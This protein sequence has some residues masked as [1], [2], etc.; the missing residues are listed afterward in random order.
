MVISASQSPVDF[1]RNRPI[2]TTVM[3]AKDAIYV[4]AVAEPQEDKAI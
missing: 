4:T 2:W 1:K 3:L